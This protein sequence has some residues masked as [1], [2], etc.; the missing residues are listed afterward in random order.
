MRAEDRPQIGAEMS[1]V[2]KPWANSE[3]LARVRW[4]IGVRELSSHFIFRAKNIMICARKKKCFSISLSCDKWWFFRTP[5]TK[6]IFINFELFI[7]RKIVTLSW[8]IQNIFLS[9]YHYVYHILFR[10]TFYG[11]AAV[12]MS[13]AFNPSENLVWG[14]LKKYEK[15]WPN[16]D[17][18]GTF[19]IY[20]NFSLRQ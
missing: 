7:T 9:V 12:S 19:P 1:P 10:A 17:Q 11:P 13:P 20:S 4:G 6:K 5:S 15:L 3:R 16:L 14:I 2:R 8:E 18:S